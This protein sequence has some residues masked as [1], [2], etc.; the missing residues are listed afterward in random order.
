[1]DD[2]ESAREATARYIA[3][4]VSSVKIYEQL[5]PEVLAEIAR[6]AEEPNEPVEGLPKMGRNT[7]LIASNQISRLRPIT[8]ELHATKNRSR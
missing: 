2:V 8:Q 1:M 3:D 6:V 5:K 7:T 4:G